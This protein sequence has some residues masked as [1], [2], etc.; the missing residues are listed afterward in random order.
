MRLWSL[1]PGQETSMV[2]IPRPLWSSDVRYRRASCCSSRARAH[3]EKLPLVGGGKTCQPTNSKS[4][5]PKRSPALLA[6]VWYHCSPPAWPCPVLTPVC[7]TVPQPLL[8]STPWV[9]RW[10]VALSLWVAFPIVLFYVFLKEMSSNLPGAAPAS[11]PEVW[12]GGAATSGWTSSELWMF[13]YGGE[14]SEGALGGKV[15]HLQGLGEPVWPSEVAGCTKHGVLSWGCGDA[16]S[17]PSSAI[18]EPGVEQWQWAQH[19]V[20]LLPGQPPFIKEKHKKASEFEVLS[21]AHTVVRWASWEAC[22]C[23]IQHPSSTC[24]GTP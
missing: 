23:C 9:G 14:F 10:D 21:T 20:L 11:G 4:P 3:P 2:L 24:T 22:G 16:L 6:V 13:L 19:S 12:R 18:G 17:A 1:L 8:S 5:A 15:L 7:P